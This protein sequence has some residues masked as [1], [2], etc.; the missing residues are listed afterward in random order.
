MR[1]VP[2]TSSAYAERVIGGYYLDIVPDR[3]ALARYGLM[4][5]DVQDVDRD[6]ARRRD[7]HDHGRGPRALRAST[8]AT[9][10]TCA[11]IRS[12]S[13]RGAGPAAGRRHGAARRSRRGSKLTRG[14]DLDPHRERPAR[15]LHLRRH[16]AAAT[17]AA[18]SPTR[19]RRCAE[20]V[21][22]PTGIY[23]RVERAVRISGARRGAAEDRR[24]ADAAH[25][26]PAALPQLPAH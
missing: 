20:Q 25:H 3:A 19:R 10:A 12:R 24:A 4:V 23:A 1:T 8:S 9:R 15:D 6:G 14:A 7:G 11:A 16:R 26:L 17:S 22:L 2:G 13:P 18:T 21:E 5:G